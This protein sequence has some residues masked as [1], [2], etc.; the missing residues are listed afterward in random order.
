MRSPERVLN[1]LSE[2]SSDL[3]YKFERLYRLLF[4]E[5]MYYVAYEHIYAKTGN[6]TKGT[7][8]RTI[9]DMS[10]GRIENLI[11]AIKNETYQ[12]KPARRVYIPKKNGKMRPLGIPSIDDKLVQ[13]IVRMILEAIYENSF[14]ETSHGFR[15]QKSCHSALTQI[16]RRFTATKWFIEGDIEGFFNNINHEVLIGIL[17]ERIS[18]ERF[19]RLI[20]K[21]LKAGYIEDWKFYNTS[22]G[23]P[24]GG[25]ISPILANIYLDKLDKYME[26]YADRFNSGELRK[27]NVEYVKLTKQIERLR[28]Q[29]KSCTSENVRIELLKAI[30][31]AK[32]A[33][34]QFPSGDEMDANYRR[35]K[36]T[37]YADDFLIGV[38]GSKADCEKIKED[39]RL[40]LHEKLKLT[41]S[42]E[43]TLITHA[44]DAAKFLGYE[45]TVR[46]S[47]SQTKRI[48]TGS[49][50]KV[51]GKRV[52][53]KIP[54]DTAK[55]KLLEYGV[56]QIKFHNGKEIWKPKSREHLASKTDIEILDTYNA[57][58]RGMANYYAIASN[59]GAELNSFKYIMQYSM[60]KTFAHKYN[61][62]VSKIL[63]KYRINKEFTVYYTN[64]KNEKIKR[65]FF[66]E[67]FRC[68]TERM[69]SLSKKVSQSKIA[70][71][72]TNLIKRL[73]AGKCEL[74]GK[75]EQSLTMHQV[76]KLKDLK[77]ELLW[78]KVMIKQRKKT[79]AVCE[80]CHN[81][82]HKSKLM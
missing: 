43:K 73:K 51:Y 82:I 28:K 48:K 78:E 66:N 56:L 79:L 44:N 64:K 33:R 37:R 29:L 9:D 71:C 76:K 20:R 50:A 57:E 3:N 47:S 68:K 18:D 54:V 55:K 77:G 12:P 62:Q 34:L 75:N 53:L 63:K 46:K 27:D 35:I 8:G 40:F 70:N 21:F 31:E 11:E 4:N 38:I 60:Y 25:I 45:I 26:E 17:K 41:L 22:N 7:D 14:E 61:T 59:S 36:Y 39:I 74:C 6:M 15:P 67:S 1:S 10:T 5:D 16:H 42:S 2:H 24:Q 80:C 52:V 32:T 81:A 58:I 72:Q 69:C 49:L 30:K 65:V 23:T 19:I 13:E